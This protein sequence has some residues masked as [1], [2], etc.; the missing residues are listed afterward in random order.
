MGGGGRTDQRTGRSDER[1]DTRGKP[2]VRPLLVALAKT[3]T[4]EGNGGLKKGEVLENRLKF[5]EERR[6]ELG[7][8][9]LEVK[10]LERNL[11]EEFAVGFEK[12][13]GK[14]FHR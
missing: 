14:V 12:K 6:T 13:K 9:T 2:S 8:V 10:F 4:V 5:P 3:T 1:S 7:H 11:G